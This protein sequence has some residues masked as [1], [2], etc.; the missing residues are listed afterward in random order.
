MERTPELIRQLSQATFC[1]QAIEELAEPFENTPVADL[2]ALAAQLTEQGE[3]TALDRLLNACAFA[4]IKLDPTVL[5]ES[6]AVIEDVTH[7]PCCYVTQGPEAIDP[8][9]KMAHAQT[10]SQQRQALLGRLATELSLRHQT[11]QDDVNRL[12]QYLLEEIQTPPTSILVID[13]IHMLTNNELKEV[14]FPILTDTHIRNTLPKRPPQK[15]IGGGET[16]RRPIAKLGRNEPCH[17]GSGKKYKRCCLEKDQAL[18]ADASSYEGITQ[19]QLMENPGLVDDENVIHNLRAY[20]IKKLTPEKLSTPQLMA[21]YQKACG[22]G[23]LDVAFSMLDESPRRSDLPRP[24]D[25]MHFYDLMELAL[26]QNNLELAQ[27]ARARIPQDTD[28]I[29]WDEIDFQFEFR[30]NPGHLQTIE[31]RCKDAFCCLPDE[32]SGFRDH[33]FCELAHLFHRQFPALS[34][35]FARAAILECP[36][37]LLDNDLLIENIHQA[38]IELGLPPWEDPADSWV[39]EQEQEQDDQ[40]QRSKQ[41]EEADALRKQLAA[42]R[43]KIR[44]AEKGLHDKEALLT[45]LKQ[46]LEDAAAQKENKPVVSEEPHRPAQQ[47]NQDTVTRLRHQIETLKAEIGNQQNKRQQ[48]RRELDRERK[49]TQNAPSTKEPAK[50]TIGT[51]DSP[52]PERPEKPEQTLLIPDYHNHFRDACQ[53]L[54]AA[55]TSGAMKALTSF[56][57]YDPAVWRNTRGIK[58]LPN[59]YRVRIGRN[60]RLLLSWIPGQS[61]TALDLIPRQDLES[62]IRRHA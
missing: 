38:R 2:N 11:R 56:A 32:T 27:R 8:L 14:A 36:D 47:P 55:T 41:A 39:T 25:P 44:A 42:S 18:L 49:Q 22:F 17:C 35:L 16:I 61:L 24:F 9:I 1:R 62:W 37:R 4:E 3:D 15:S 57:V 46:E 10:L 60:H 43:Q 53:R 28:W 29:C 26:E 7:L 58:Q 19:S 54:P 31:T 30:A 5:A 6:A 13:S 40:T 59:I 12:L 48:L 34:I 33:G 51:E 45:E 23:L 52:I 21:A 20:E 50:D